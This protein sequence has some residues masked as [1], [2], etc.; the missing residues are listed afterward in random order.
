MSPLFISSVYHVI[1]MYGSFVKFF[2]TML[3]INIDFS[4][5]HWFVNATI[6]TFN[7]IRW[8]RLQINVA[9]DKKKNVNEDK[10]REKEVPIEIINS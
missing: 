1:C 3:L 8:W 4:R 9:E 6:L 10:M 5:Q 2:Y 7:E